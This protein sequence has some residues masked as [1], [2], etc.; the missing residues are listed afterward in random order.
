MPS[1]IPQLSCQFL[2]TKLGVFIS[3]A[4]RRKPAQRGEPLSQHVQVRVA[5]LR[6]EKPD[7][8]QGLSP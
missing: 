2:M 5:E 4:Q 1:V 3:T 6:W 8:L 7:N